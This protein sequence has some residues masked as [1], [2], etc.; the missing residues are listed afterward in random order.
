MAHPSGETITDLVSVYFELTAEDSTTQLLPRS[1]Q[2]P[3]GV[4]WRGLSSPERRLHR[5]VEQ[6][7]PRRL[8]S[9]R[10]VF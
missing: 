8:A 6:Q 9:L 3:R 2:D 7:L 4:P 1:Q 10:R 5:P